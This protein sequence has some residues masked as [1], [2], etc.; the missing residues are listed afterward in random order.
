M[1]PF[2]NLKVHTS[3]RTFTSVQCKS[4][5]RGSR[6]RKALSRHWFKT[7]LKLYRAWASLEVMKVPTSIRKR[8]DGNGVGVGSKGEIVHRRCKPFPLPRYRNFA[9]FE[10][11]KV[12]VSWRLESGLWESGTAQTPSSPDPGENF[13][14]SVKPYSKR[15][16]PDTKSEISKMR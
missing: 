4:G 16:S 12:S 10:N 6:N 9:F 2:E 7:Q 1:L 13:L 11:A 14:S 3:W 15:H 8:C 5:Q